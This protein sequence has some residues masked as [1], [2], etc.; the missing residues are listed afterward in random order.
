MLLSPGIIDN[1][2]RKVALLVSS[3]D[4]YHDLWRP[5]FT[6]LWRYWPDCPF[7]VYLI[8]NYV[9]YEDPRVT[10]LAVGEDRH[11]ASNCRAALARVPF[12]YVLY[13][14][15]DSFFYQ[16]VDTRRVLELAAFLFQSDGACMRLF[17]SPG[18]DA[19]V[20]ESTEVG[21]ISPGVPYRVALQA[22]IWHK[23]TLQGLLVDGE[24][25]WEM[26]LIGSRR[27]DTLQKPFFSV[28][29]DPTTGKNTNAPLPYL[30]R[31]CV[32]GK[33]TRGAVRFCMREKVPLD[34]SMRRV[35]PWWYHA[36]ERSVLHQIYVRVRSFGGES[37]RRVGLKH[38]SRIESRL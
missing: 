20:Q 16:A 23:E 4:E 7:R 32:K 11:W 34:L 21:L 29:M 14:E 26:E 9:T 33:L 38:H 19:P 12:P 8:S 35:Y 15:E 30:S 22:A 17:P 31:V 6:L 28:V 24:T 25:G 10:P 2:K 5:F 27:S 1:V 13:V 3:C 37:L 36:W 18:P